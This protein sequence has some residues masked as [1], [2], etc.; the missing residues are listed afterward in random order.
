MVNSEATLTEIN[1]YE[2]S[3]NRRLLVLYIQTRIPSLTSVLLWPGKPPV[4]A[5]ILEKRVWAA[6]CQIAAEV[7]W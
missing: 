7:G 4:S 5:A 2:C 6:Q 3:N 1:S